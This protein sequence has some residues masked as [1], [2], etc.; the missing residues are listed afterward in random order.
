MQ[1]HFSLLIAL[2]LLVVPDAKAQ[3]KPNEKDGVL[4]PYNRGF[5]KRSAFRYNG[6]IIGHRQ[7]QKLMLD[8][9]DSRP[10][11]QKALRQRRGGMYSAIGGLCFTLAAISQSGKHTGPSA[12]NAPRR[13]ATFWGIGLMGII[14]GEVFVYNGNRQAHNALNLFNKETLAVGPAQQPVGKVDTTG[15]ILLNRGNFHSRYYY[16]GKPIGLRRLDKLL[17]ESP[18]ARP[19]YQKMQSN[20]KVALVSGIA[21]GAMLGLVIVTGIPFDKDVDNRSNATEARFFVSLGAATVAGTIWGVA[22]RRVLEHRYNAYRLFNG[23]SPVPF[24]RR[25]QRLIDRISLG[26]TPNG[27]GLAVHFR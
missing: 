5:M 27:I 17:A 11:M 1:T 9:P 7:A 10:L 15:K 3:L 26:A 23:E 6:A 20:K 18:G 25:T 4:Y 19:F 21:T 16:Q 24:D 8:N 2:A 14:V 22:H 13:A 12:V